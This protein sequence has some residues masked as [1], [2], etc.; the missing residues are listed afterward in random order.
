MSEA[1][2]IQVCCLEGGAVVRLTLARPKANVLDAAMVGA[3]REA[4]AEHAANANVRAVLLRA[5]GPHFS[6]GASVEEHLPDQVA[7]M[8]RGFHQLFRELIALRKPVLVAVQGQCLGGGLELALAGQ[9][10]FAGTDAVFGQPELKLGVLA[11]V[12]SLLLPRRVGQAHAD[13]LLLSGRSVGAD[14]ALAMGLVDDIAHDPEAAALDWI[15][16]HLL[17]KSAASLALAVA[18]ARHEADRAF[19]AHID[20]LESLYL[21]QLMRHPDAEE[22]IRAFLEKRQPVWSHGEEIR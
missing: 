22:G 17:D 18:A 19:L 1:A 14:E 10:I 16:T 6:F 20:A 13:D 9:R 8:L 2:P 12:G 4:L 5:A 15:R 11:P 3:L 21:E 7:G